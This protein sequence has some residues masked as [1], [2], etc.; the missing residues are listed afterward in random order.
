MDIGAFG[1]DDKQSNVGN[2]TVYPLYLNAMK[3]I[4]TLCNKSLD[5]GSI[6]VIVTKDKVKNN[7]RVYIGKDNARLCIETGFM[8]EDWHLRE[9]GSGIR[10]IVPQKRRIE[11]GI[12]KPELMIVHEDLIVFRKVKD[13]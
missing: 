7:E 5:I 9:A 3:T 8:M 2:L 1:Y 13:V 11:K 6:M 10:Q 12:D 4:Y